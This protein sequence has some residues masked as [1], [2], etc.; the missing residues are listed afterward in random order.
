MDELVAGHGRGRKVALHSNHAHQGQHLHGDE[1]P[2]R[3]VHGAAGLVPEAVVVG[4]GG[5]EAGGS[6]EGDG[7]EERRAQRRPAPR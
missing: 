1:D 7:E 3:H 6:A 4:G 2:R 5:E